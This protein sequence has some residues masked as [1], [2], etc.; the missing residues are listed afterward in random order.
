MDEGTWGLSELGERRAVPFLEKE[1]CYWG[2]PGDDATATREMDRSR[3][4][5]ADF[6]VFAWQSFWM[7]DHFRTF[8]RQL[9][10]AF[11]CI[12]DN[13]R[14]KI[15]RFT[16]ERQERSKSVDASGGNRQ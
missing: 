12:L 8:D 4:A 7:L 14:L 11:P 6:I 1:G 2:P 15:F 13:D 16:L 3:E 5:G 10:T 9:R